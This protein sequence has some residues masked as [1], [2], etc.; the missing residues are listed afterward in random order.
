M[1]ATVFHQIASTLLLLTFLDGIVFSQKVPCAPHGDATQGFRA[2]FFPGE[3]NNQKALQSR[4]FLVQDYL[5]TSSI[6]EVDGIINPNFNIRPCYIDPNKRTCPLNSDYYSLGFDRY[7]CG[8]KICENKA[9]GVVHDVNVLGFRT[10]VTNFTLELTGYIKVDV[11]GVYKFV[12][13]AADDVAGIAIGGGTAFDCCDTDVSSALTE[14]YFDTDGVKNWGKYQSPVSSNVYLYSGMYYPVRMM[15]ANIYNYAHLETSVILPNGKVLSNWGSLVYNFKDNTTSDSD[16]CTLAAVTAPSTFSTLPDPTSIIP[17]AIDTTVSV[18]V[19]FTETF[20]S[21]M[22]T[23]DDNGQTLYV[24]VTETSVITAGPSSHTEIT[25]TMP[26]NISEETSSLSSATFTDDNLSPT[27]DNIHSSSSFTVVDVSPDSTSDKSSEVYATSA[28]NDISSTFMT[29]PEKT[30]DT[31]G[32]SATSSGIISYLSSSS[33]DDN[34]NHESSTL[35][36][37]M[38]ST[39]QIDTG[40]SSITVSE[41]GT[42]EG[43]F[44]SS[45]NSNYKTTSETNGGHLSHS[46]SNSNIPGA[47][48]GTT[49]ELQ[50]TQSQTSGNSNNLISY[51][52]TLS[53]PKETSYLPSSTDSGETASLDNDQITTLSSISSGLSR[54]KILSSRSHEIPDNNSDILEGQTQSSDFS[55]IV[56]S[57]TLSNFKTTLHPSEVTSDNLAS[58]GSTNP[59]IVTSSS[60]SDNERPL[61]SP[62]SPEYTSSFSSGYSSTHAAGYSSGS[63]TTDKTVPNRSNVISV[64]P[65]TGI[66]TK[67]LSNE[68]QEHNSDFDSDHTDVC[69]NTFSSGQ[70]SIQN[71]IETSHATDNSKATTASSVSEYRTSSNAA[72]LT[73]TGTSEFSSSYN[74]GY[75]AGYSAGYNAGFSIGAK[76]HFTIG[77]G[78]GSNSGPM[79]DLI[80]TGDYAKGFAAGYQNGYTA[81]YIAGENSLSSS[82]L[83]SNSGSTFMNS[84]PSWGNTGSVLNSIPTGIV[85]SDISSSSRFNVNSMA[86]IPATTP[87][88]SNITPE[89][90]DNQNSATTETGITILSQTSHF[91]SDSSQIDHTMTKTMDIINLDNPSTT[92][93]SNKYSNSTTAITSKLIETTPNHG[94]DHLTKSLN[95]FAD[96]QSTMMLIGTVSSERGESL[97]LFKSSPYEGQVSST[98]APPLTAVPNMPASSSTTIVWIDEGGSPT[99]KNTSFNSF[100]ALLLLLLF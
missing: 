22:T 64:P 67:T 6:G 46:Q 4:N 69:I 83:Y 94:N 8:A 10:T 77:A 15:Y 70:T 7:F 72:F 24:T 39:I 57:E 100:V 43:P 81:G 50:Q 1:T 9:T 76:P 89:S 44:P 66:N 74:A 55:I 91:P 17:P 2:R 92:A 86:S 82:N 47:S 31:I 65:S 51:S 28:G 98:N 60:Q 93:K 37:H 34:S 33:V 54:S 3:L 52:S 19:T 16:R 45:L 99:T 21:Q 73:T 53:T 42:I 85:T 88:T 90:S 11:T 26:S 96:D 30:H 18:S 14:P 80:S 49:D 63:D 62:P 71:S 41:S 84:V 48:R 40:Y 97:L 36:G 38:S 23:T 5:R 79:T 32:I 35:V 61:I 75:N 20:T 27:L 12:I 25:D 56:P 95:D 58:F 68:C 13:N 59:N 87:E 78:T 29:L